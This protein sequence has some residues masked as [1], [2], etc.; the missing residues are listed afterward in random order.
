M[1]SY[2][3]QPRQLLLN[4]RGHQLYYKTAS[5][6]LLDEDTKQRARQQPGRVWTMKSKALFRKE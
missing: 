2:A 5:T 6:A 1:L 3:F 4:F